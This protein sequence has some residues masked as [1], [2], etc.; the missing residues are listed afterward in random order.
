VRS[1]RMTRKQADAEYERIK[2]N[3]K[4]EGRSCQGTASRN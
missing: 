2:E 3:S 4:A 1:G